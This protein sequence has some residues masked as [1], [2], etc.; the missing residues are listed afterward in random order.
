[1]VYIAA[2]DNHAYLGPAPLPEMAQQI[3][4]STGPSG[5]NLDYLLQLAEALRLIEA[6]DPHVFELE[7]AVRRYGP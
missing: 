6:D 3:A 4:T 1:V 5:A 7:A 2:T